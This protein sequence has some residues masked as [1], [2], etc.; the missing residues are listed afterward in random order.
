MSTT[1]TSPD[2]V[3]STLD[4]NCPA[5]RTMV[6]HITSKWGVLVLLLLDGATLRWSEVK[7]AIPGVSEKMLIQ[8]LQTLE[9]DGLVHRAALPVVPP[10]VEYS[11]TPDGAE[12]SRLLRPLVAWAQGHAQE[13]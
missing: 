13:R 9:S 8:T 3:L 6:E 12:A 11:L 4:T 10:H 1:P 2:V 5:T 7:R